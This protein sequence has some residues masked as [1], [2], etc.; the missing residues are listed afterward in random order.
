MKSEPISSYSIAYRCAQSIQMEAD[1]NE[2][3]LEC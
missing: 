1:L 3:G 2:D